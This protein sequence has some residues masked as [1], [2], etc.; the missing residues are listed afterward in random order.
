[1]LGVG[2]LPQ[3]LAQGGEHGN[4]A[5][6]ELVAQGGVVGDEARGAA[7]GMLGKVPAY[8][9]RDECLGLGLGARRGLPAHRRAAIGAASPPAPTTP[10]PTQGPSPA[11][12]TLNGIGSSMPAATDSNDRPRTTAA[13]KGDSRTA[14]YPSSRV[15]LRAISP[16]STARGT[17]MSWP[18]AMRASSSRP[19]NRQVKDP[20]SSI[21]PVA[22]NTG[23]S[24]FT[25]LALFLDALS[26]DH[27]VS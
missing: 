25:N 7:A 21:S 16:S 27:Q 18:R 19:P 6:R 24:S 14:P 15:R 22:M 23:V 26:L 12:H 9:G 11:S 8:G 1:M 4:A 5:A 20:G 13:S 10:R 17:T 3:E 2:Q